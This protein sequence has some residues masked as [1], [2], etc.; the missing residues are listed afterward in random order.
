M[1]GDF[2]CSWSDPVRRGR[3]RV[4]QEDCEFRDLELLV[5]C[6]VFLVLFLSFGN[7]N[8]RWLRRDVKNVVVRGL[9]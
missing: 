4:Q 5:F 1:D 6:L 7:E 8:G 2:G 9:F 3:N